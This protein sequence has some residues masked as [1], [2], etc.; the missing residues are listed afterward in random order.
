MKNTSID[1]LTSVSKVKEAARFPR[2]TPELDFSARHMEVG[3]ER[4]SWLK[5]NGLESHVGV[6]LSSVVLPIRTSS[7]IVLACRMRSKVGSAAARP[8]AT[9]VLYCS[10]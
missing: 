2:I 5:K 3:L 6:R 10:L 4:R 1:T 9:R 7:S 8:G